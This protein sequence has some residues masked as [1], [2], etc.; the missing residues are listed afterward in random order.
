MAELASP[1]MGAINSARGKS[2]SGPSPAEME[3]RIAIS[4]LIGGLGARLDRISRD[5][6][7]T[8][9]VL[10][11][12]RLTVEQNTFLD[13]QKEAIELDRERRLAEQ[14]LREGQESLI[15]RKIENAAIVP[16]QKQVIRARSSLNNL[17]T[18]FG[19]L[20][21]GWL[22]IKVFSNFENIKKF[23]LDKLGDTKEFFQSVFTQIGNLF[24]GINTSFSNLF[25]NI[26]RIDNILKSAF[27]N[28]LFRGGFNFL[29]S[30]F[31]NAYNSLTNIDL[32]KLNPLNTNPGGGGP[33]GPGESNRP[34]TTLELNF[35]AASGLPPL[36][37]NLN[38]SDFR[39][40]ATSNYFSMNP[41][42]VFNKDGGQMNAS[43]LYTGLA[44]KDF[45]QMIGMNLNMGNQGFDA[46]SMMGGP[47]TNTSG[48]IPLQI[49]PFSGNTQALN[50][51]VGS[52]LAPVA[53]PQTN[54]VVSAAPPAP[55]IVPSGLNRNAN[56]IPEISSSNPDNFYVYFSMT[57][58][59]VVM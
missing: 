36:A 4:N 44:G 9:N 11:R 54:V 41:D 15:E 31:E 45:L 56:G 17:V 12:V 27:N 58:Y 59:N 52:E 3:D 47:A 46:S 30:I 20:L 14:Q 26:G 22:S 1:I 48:P 10:E 34:D 53:Q 33:P 40:G 19:A 16:A 38:L 24:K 51:S 49:V 43:S 55:Q 35:A 42:T 50:G 25:T 23:T 37:T 18:L 13:R 39:T 29:K 2:S 5:I 6:F 7:D 32:S 8:T 21:G 57:H 28:D